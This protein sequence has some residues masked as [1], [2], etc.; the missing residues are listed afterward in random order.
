METD[1][2]PDVRRTYETIRCPACTA[3]QLGEIVTGPGLPW[4]VVVHHCDRCGYLIHESE[5]ES[6]QCPARPGESSANQAPTADPDTWP[7][8]RFAC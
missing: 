4:P 7:S 3:I 1:D 8:F 6:A 2:I 5:W